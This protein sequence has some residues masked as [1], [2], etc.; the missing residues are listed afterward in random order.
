MS[1]HNL[2]NINQPSHF[3]HAAGHSD[4]N[5]LRKK[6]VVYAEETRAMLL[7]GVVRKDPTKPM[8]RPVVGS[9][10]EISKPFQLIKSQ[11]RMLEPVQIKTP[12]HRFE[13]TKPRSF[14][15]AINKS[16]KTLITCSYNELAKHEEEIGKNRLT[17]SFY[18]LDRQHCA[19]VQSTL[20]GDDPDISLSMDRCRKASSEKKKIPIFHSSVLLYTSDQKTPA[21]VVPD[22]ELSSLGDKVDYQITAPEFQEFSGNKFSFYKDFTRLYE[23]ENVHQK[24]LI[25]LLTRS[26]DNIHEDN[27][28]SISDDE[29]LQMIHS[30]M[31]HIGGK[32]LIND[33]ITNELLTVYKTGIES[34]PNQRELALQLRF[35]LRNFPKNDLISL[36]AIIGHIR[37]IAI[38][39]G[40]YKCVG[41]LSSL[42]SE[43]IF[44]TQSPEGEFIDAT[45]SELYEI[46]FKRNGPQTQLSGMLELVIKYYNIFF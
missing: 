37:R 33:E 21:T 6:A 40:Y 23:F 8:D 3:L 2:I 30:L 17:K 11:D 22:E 26:L 31:V 5:A 24:N 42:F 10:F 25:S 18:E 9:S 41:T 35:C 1:L 44:S 19:S 20:D 14:L 46:I 32:V 29:L 34:A 16:D 7:K 13:V 12:K 38:V 43:L 27:V 36:K 45:P 28:G 15:P 39:Y 4:A